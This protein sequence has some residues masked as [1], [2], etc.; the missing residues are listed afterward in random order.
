MFLA[1]LNNYHIRQVKAQYLAV[2]YEILGNKLDVHFIL[3]KEYLENYKEQSRWEVKWAENHWG[4]YEDLMARLTPDKYTLISTPDILSEEDTSGYF[5]KKSRVPSDILRETV[6][7]RFSEQE[8][9]IKETVKEKNIEAAVTWV[10]NNCLKETL[11]TFGIPVIHHEL[12]PFRPQ[13][14]IPTAYLDFS[15]VNGNTEFEERFKE[16]LK[17]S[18]EVPLLN[19]KELI[20]VLSPQHYKE[21]WEVLEDSSCTYEAGVG[22]Q[23]EVD[24]NLL[25]FNNGYNWIDPLLLAESE[26]K[27]KV[28]VRPH[29]MAGYGLKS[30][31][32]KRVIDDPLKS[33]AYEFINKCK[34]IYC[35]NSSVGAEAMLL[36]REA[37]ILGDSPF[38]CLCKLKG[39][40]QIKAI[41][42]MVFGYLIH[43]NLLFNNDYYRFRLKNR[44][45]EKL[46]YTDNMKRLIN[47]CLKK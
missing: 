35:L 40:L 21:L 26:S 11:K 32:G 42:F 41:N 27:G 15:G 45:N 44:G 39:D 28:L 6:Y 23:V 3:P 2:L 20:K 37:V 36:G 18:D 10:N 33:K 14:Y 5:L 9:I 22:M 34:K 38:R 8:E 16:F 25:L 17:I 29:P 4:K 13:T 31:N 1:Y 7:G 47:N 12:G 46:I 24:T 30:V 43:R 19:R